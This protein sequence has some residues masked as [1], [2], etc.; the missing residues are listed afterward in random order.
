VLLPAWKACLEKLKLL[1]RIMSRD[2][3]TQWNSTYDMLSFVVT[4]RKAIE[5]LT[6]ECKNNL[7]Q[8][9]LREDEWVIA[10]ELCNTLKVRRS[11]AVC[12]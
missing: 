4:Y 9:E 11:D 12:F 8:Y 5:L 10:N 6:S 7:R 1:L 3:T 2:V